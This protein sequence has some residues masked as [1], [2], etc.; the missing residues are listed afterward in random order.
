MSEYEFLCW[1]ATWLASKPARERVVD[2][3]RIIR[4]Y[5]V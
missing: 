1:L 5:G 3:M 2:V 4:R